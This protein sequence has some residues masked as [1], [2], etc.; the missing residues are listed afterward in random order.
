MIDWDKPLRAMD[1][2]TAKLITR[3]TTNSNYPMGVLIQSKNGEEYVM[4]TELGKYYY[5]DGSSTSYDLENVPE[6]IVRYVNYYTTGASYCCNTR[7]SADRVSMPNRVS[8]VRVEF[9]VGQFDD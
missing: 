4:Y 2:R 9:E 5:N 3:K 7:D 8:R 1:G 6:K